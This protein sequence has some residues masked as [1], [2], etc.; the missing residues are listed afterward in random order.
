VTV[1]PLIETVGS[2]D[3][4]SLPIVRTGP[5]PLIVVAEH[6]LALEVAGVQL[7]VEAQVEVEADRV[8]VVGCVDCGLNRREASGRATDAEVACCTGRISGRGGQASA[9]QRQAEYDG[10]TPHFILLLE[11]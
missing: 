1:T 3:A 2:L 5:P 11:T 7:E 10:R 8:A 9:N 4:N 6:R